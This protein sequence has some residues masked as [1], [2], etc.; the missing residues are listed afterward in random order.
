MPLLFF[1]ILV[2]GDGSDQWD[3]QGGWTTY[4]VCESRRATAALPTT[5]WYGQPHEYGT[6][7]CF[8]MGG[9]D[10]HN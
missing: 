9:R 7:R 8:L 4:S 3:T 2:W 5:S 10:A 1:F 6:S